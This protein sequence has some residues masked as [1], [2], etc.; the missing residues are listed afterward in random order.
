MYGLAK[1]E[2]SSPQSHEEIRREV[3][4]GRL[5]KLAHENREIRPY[6]ATAVVRDLSWELA[7]YLDTELLAAAAPPRTPN[8]R[9]PESLPGGARR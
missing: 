2:D 9:E 8:Q 1:Y 5:E 7:R 3:A 4:V 6:V